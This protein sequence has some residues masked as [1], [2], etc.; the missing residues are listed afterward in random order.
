MLMP[1]RPP[2]FVRGS[3]LWLLLI[4][5]LYLAGLFLFAATPSR[6]PGSFNSDD[7]YCFSVCEDLLQGRDMQGWHFTAVP[8]VFPDLLLLFP[9][10]ALSSN[11]VVVILAYDFLFYS[12]LAAALAWLVRL[13]GFEWREALLT[14]CTGL[15]WLLVSHLDPAYS[16]MAGQLFQPGFHAG[17][18]LSGVLLLAIVLQV[19]RFGLHAGTILVL[20]ALC[21]LAVFSDRL[22][23]V[24]FIVPMLAGLGLL[25]FTRTVPLRRLLALAS[26]LGMGT[27][28]ASGIRWCFLQLGLVLMYTQ[29]SLRPPHWE[30]LQPFFRQMLADTPNL[31]LLPLYLV[32][33]LAV[34][35]CWRRTRAVSACSAAES[36]QQP[37]AAGRLH[38]PA[39]LFVVSVAV[40][41]PLCN[42]IAAFLH[43]Y[44][45]PLLLFV[46]PP[47]RY[48]FACWLLPFLF[49][50]LFVQLLPGWW[51]RRGGPCFRLGVVFFA[52][53]RI[54]THGA[55]MDHTPLE[56][57]YPPLAQELDRLQRE[58]GPLHGLAGY[59][60]ARSMN[61]L[62]RQR[63]RIEAVAA[64]GSPWVHAC[65]PNRF[66]ADDPADLTFP[67]YN[68]LIISPADELSP[69]AEKAR[70]EFGE[71]LE[72][73]AVDGEEIWLYERL[74]G[75]RFDRFLEAQLAQ[76]LCRREKYIAPVSPGALSVPKPNRM[77]WW[78]ARNVQPEQGKELEIC[79]DRPVSGG[80]IDVAANHSDE[81]QLGFY[82]GQELLGWV[83]VPA[84]PWTGAVFYYY[85]PSGIQ[86]RLVSV[87][88][89]LSKRSW[90]RV[91][92]RPIRASPELS[93]GHFLVFDENV[94]R[95]VQIPH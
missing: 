61:F 49:L 10:Q 43:S 15:L 59:W 79:F 25:A 48:L 78:S 47:C 64:D 4:I 72:K 91:V 70:R 34:L 40:L 71:P 44:D 45:N 69:S 57:L 53:Y 16:S 74:S 14:A 3:S 1:T 84:V 2:A 26:L 68:F 55:A 60:R 67:H 33:G 50:G 27:L 51:N 9:C 86:S 54:L 39:V 13:V 28:L 52:A 62:S 18:I 76:R 88:D 83:K 7:L 23:L 30:Y 80:L 12:L 89:A 92:V 24:E 87:A 56:P 38:R 95:R 46:P 20:L 19:L 5:G 42:V 90:N 17:A 31:F 11:L 85:P 65:N 66:L 21:P 73:I 58:R 77:S 37:E 36:G 22:L 75:P 94:A 93:L 8:Y 63:V 29:M 81:Y 32:T 6:Q 41:S 35:F 82:R